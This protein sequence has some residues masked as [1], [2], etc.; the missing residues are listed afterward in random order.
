MCDALLAILHAHA[1]EIIATRY[2]KDIWLH[3]YIDGSAQ[4]DSTAGASFYWQ[5]LFMGSCAVGLGA[6]NLEAEIEAIRQ[7]TSHLSDLTTS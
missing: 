7:V 3:I 6:R 5:N 2:L 4:E 1:L